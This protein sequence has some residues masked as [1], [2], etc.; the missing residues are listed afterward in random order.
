VSDTDEAASAQR[1]LILDT[2]TDFVIRPLFARVA[3]TIRADVELL[4]KIEGFNPGGS[5]KLK[6]ALALVRQLVQTGVLRPGMSII[7]S[8]SGNMG[9]ALSLIARAQGFDFV[10]VSDEK[11][12]NHNRLLL[13]ALSAR[14]VILPGSTY[15]Q[16]C[17]YI[18]E[19]LV[20]D[21][22]LVWT[23]QFENP[24][25][26]QAHAES[27]A[28]EILNTVGEVDHLFI[29]VGTGGTL[30]GCAQVFRRLSPETRIVA[31]DTEGSAHFGNSPSRTRRRI[32]GIGA[33]EPSRFIH[34]SL[35][36]EFVLVPES[37]AVR[38]CKQLARATGW[39]LGGSSGSVVS[40][41]MESA[42]QFAPDDRVVAIC[43]DLGD[44]YLDSIYSTQ[45]LQ[46][47]NS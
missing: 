28:L 5:I 22:C 2:I 19:Q 23:R 1:G 30:A 24:S 39:L 7:E 26:P 45:W 13:G 43:A 10:C 37:R 34:P 32:P 11:I 38:A 46:D 6:P 44:R 16:R 25:N 47:E 29:G 15:R 42:C 3:N 12:T 40:A 14:L 41:V 27:T 35:F 9:I 36:D 4:L 21:P 17:A 31:V 20:A 33:S 8:S 18:E